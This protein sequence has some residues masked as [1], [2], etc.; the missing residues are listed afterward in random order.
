MKPS[1]KKKKLKEITWRKIGLGTYICHQDT[2]AE[3]LCRLLTTGLQMELFVVQNWGFGQV[4]AEVCV[5]KNCAMRLELSWLG[6]LDNHWPGLSLCVCV[7][8]YIYFFVFLPNNMCSVGL[9]GLPSLDW[10]FW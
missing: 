4:H 3:S 5:L 6:W 10:R 1:Q 9:I 2:L 7:I 8:V